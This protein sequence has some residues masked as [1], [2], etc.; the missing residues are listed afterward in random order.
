MDPAKSDWADE[1]R[2]GKIRGCLC[3]GRGELL[4][5]H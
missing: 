3:V 1:E 5:G 4:G 2:L